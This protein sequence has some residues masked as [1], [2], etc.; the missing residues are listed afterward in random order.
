[1]LSQVYTVGALIPMPSDPR[2]QPVHINP[3]AMPDPSSLEAAKAANEAERR[4]YVA[5]VGRTSP[6]DGLVAL[7]DLYPSSR[8]EDI[9]FALTAFVDL[10]EDHGTTT[11]PRV[12][13]RYRL[14][15]GK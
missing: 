13:M 7:L 10:I 8:H 2:E 14:E 9:L 11:M 4:R 5:D 1:M 15:V 3:L 6:R 12:L